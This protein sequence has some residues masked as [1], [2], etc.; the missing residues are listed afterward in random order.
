MSSRRQFLATATAALGLGALSACNK[1]EE[2]TAS[3]SAA[4]QETI[5]WKMVTSWPANFPG[6][7]TGASRIAEYIN[8]LSGGRITV[9]VYA[10]GELVGAL[11]VFDAV[12]AG[13]AQLG[14]SGA[15]YWKGKSRAAQFFSSVPFGLTAQEMNAWLFYGDG[16]K[17][18]E[19]TYKPFGLIPGAGGNS[20][21]QMGGWFNKEINSVA[22]FKGLKMRMPGLG[23]EVIQRLGA[24][25]V[26]LPGGE[27]F[28]ALQS[29]A[30]DATEWVGP[31]NDQ[32]FGL[33]KA[34]KNYYAP[35]WHEPGTTMECM[36]NEKAYSD[37]PADLQAIVKA[38]IRLVNHDM[39]AEY[40]ARNQSALHEL[41]SQHGVKVKSFPDDVLRELKKLSDAVLD[42][43]AAKDPLSQKVWASQKAFRDAVAPWTA[44][45]EGAIIHARN[46]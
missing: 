10:A 4:K 27:I 36:M 13:T 33:Y 12:S 42:E 32:A 44:V 23:G 9:K 28:T 41:E 39:L 21:T 20:G 3:A 30:I 19:E 8:T 2:A 45:A 25:P 22:D 17:L 24:I 31:Y 5:H 38:A 34:A 11:E 1:K 15:Y 26:N 43:E 16:M 46:L 40:T 7:G 29:G 14:H 37:L 35:G 18:W 6:L